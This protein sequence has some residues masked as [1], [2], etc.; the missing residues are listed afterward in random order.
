MMAAIEIP[1]KSS[2]I[3]T[4]LLMVFSNIRLPHLTLSVTELKSKASEVEM[5]L[6]KHIV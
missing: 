5:S 4:A 2:N 3:E 6:S 1:K